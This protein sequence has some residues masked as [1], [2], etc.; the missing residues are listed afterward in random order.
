MQTYIR[1]AL[2][3]IISFSDTYL[4][5]IFLQILT[6]QIFYKFCDRQTVLSEIFECVSVLISIINKNVQLPILH[7]FFQDN[8]S[9]PSTVRLDKLERY[10][11]QV[12]KYKK[13]KSF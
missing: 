1:I 2:I 4:L 13:L 11:E 3:S 7:Y 12:M 8:L 10:G 5:S 6:Y 9:S